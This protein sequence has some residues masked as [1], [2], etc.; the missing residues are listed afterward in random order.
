M[1]KGNQALRIGIILAI[2]ASIL[3]ACDRLPIYSHYEHTP[4]AGWEKNDV[5]KYEISP[6]K[7][8]GYYHEELGLRISDE[9]PFQGLC[10]VVHQTILPSG[11][12]HSDTLNCNLIDKNG[13]MKGSGI[14]HYQY[15]FHVNTI[16]LNEGDS[17]LIQIKHNMKREIMPCITDVGMQIEK[18]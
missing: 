16:R 2:G 18:R 13:R 15:S 12:H 5:L 17:L 4:I 9:F 11:Y 14:N 10:L 3:L 6:V 8:A 1:Q 7:E